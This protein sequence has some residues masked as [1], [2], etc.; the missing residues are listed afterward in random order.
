MS[1]VAQRLDRGSGSWVHT[2]NTTRHRAA[3]AV[4][5]VIV[6]AHWAEHIVQA[7]Q[8]WVLGWPVPEARGVLG[9]WFPWLVTSEAL[10]YGYALVMLA[11]L[12][13]L[14]PGFV[15]RARTWWTIALVIQVWHHLEHLI[16]LFQHQAGVNLAGRP[17]PTSILQ[18]QFPRVELHLFYNAVVFAPMVVAMYLHT[19]PHTGPEPAPA[20]T[21]AAVA[22]PVP[23]SAPA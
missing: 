3:L 23:A 10:H 4:F 15:G 5:L 20:C 2:L 13:M 1:V 22:A 19:R 8:I 12:I 18:L 6:L 17:V 14:R 11:G 21:C 9:G 7:I 16:L